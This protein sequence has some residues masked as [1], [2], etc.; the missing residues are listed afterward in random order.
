ME[1][2]TGQSSGRAAAARLLR[3]ELVDVGRDRLVQIIFLAAEGELDGAGVPVRE[4]AS[5]SQ[6]LQVLLQ[7][8]ERPRAIIAEAKYLA[9]NSRG[10]LTQTVR[11]GEEVWVDKPQKVG[12]PIL[13]AVVRRGG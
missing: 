6:I 3:N 4:Q 12:K 8:P 5:S 2:C 7:P 9:A 10:M 13:V 11:F 1:H